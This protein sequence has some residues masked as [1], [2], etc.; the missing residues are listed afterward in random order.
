MHQRLSELKIISEFHADVL[1]TPVEQL[2]PAFDYVKNN[3]LGGKSYQRE[4]HTKVAL[5]LKK[6]L[7][8][9]MEEKQKTLQA[10]AIRQK[11]V[12]A[13]ERVQRELAEQEAK[14]KQAQVSRLEAEV[15]EAIRQKNVAAAERAQREL[16]E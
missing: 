15:A 11:N 2:V 12:A 10:E 7:T 14:D 4:D 3:V 9:S 1:S 8:S 6:F 16:A 5:E 13:A